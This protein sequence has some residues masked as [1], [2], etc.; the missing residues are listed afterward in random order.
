[1]PDL[2]QRHRPLFNEPET[3]LVLNFGI[4]LYFVTRSV[5]EEMA[6]ISASLT[7]RVTIGGH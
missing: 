2:I 3:A 5:S 7:L 1:M 6:Q 4:E